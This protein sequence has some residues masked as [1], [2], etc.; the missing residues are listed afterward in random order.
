MYLNYL[1]RVNMKNNLLKL[2]AISA[3][4]MTGLFT[5]ITAK[6]LTEEQDY[7]LTLKALPELADDIKNSS[8]NKSAAIRMKCYVDTA[9][10]DLYTYDFC[11]SAALPRTTSAVFSID[12]VPA[13]ST[14]IWSNSSC[15]SSSFCIIPIRHY[16]PLSVNATVLKPNGTYS[17]VSATA[18][19]EG[20]D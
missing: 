11:F 3:L 13:G 16:Q 5:N 10:Y 8:L 15:N 18:Y 17:T 9:A 20:F 19:Y 4:C 12:N 1:E 14:V 2:T 7:E 6:E